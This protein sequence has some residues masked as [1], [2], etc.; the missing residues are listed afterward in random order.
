[1]YVVSY[2]T[3]K[4]ESTKVPTLGALDVHGYLSARIDHAQVSEYC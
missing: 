4:M 3:C 1:M 2:N